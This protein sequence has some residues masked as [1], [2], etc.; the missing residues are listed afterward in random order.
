MMDIKRNEEGAV[1]RLPAQFFQSASNVFYTALKKEIE[2]GVQRI[3]VDCADMTLIDSAAIG[4]L[5]SIVKDC[6]ARGIAFSIRNLS[7]EPYE[8]FVDTGLDKIFNLESGGKVQSAELDIFEKSVDIRLDMTPEIVGD[9]CIFHL[10]GMM[11]HPQG[12]RY[13]KQQFLLAMAH[14]KKMLL[15]FEDLTFFDSMSVSAVL[16]MNK[17]IMET[18]GAMRISGANSIVVD[19]FKTLNLAAIIPIYDVVNDALDGWV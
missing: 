17:L 13:F 11:N 3:V 4:T 1:V 12:S 10:S 15:D 6:R 14:H 19:L 9:V 7:G 8:L 5:V 2:A 18:G 16:N